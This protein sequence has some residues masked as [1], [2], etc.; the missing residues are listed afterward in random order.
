MAEIIDKFKEKAKGVKDVVVDTA[1][2]L[3]NIDVLTQKF[4]LEL[5]GALA[6]ENAGL[7]RL[8]TRVHEVSMPEAKQR[9]LWHIEESLEHQKILQQLVSGIGAKPTLDKLGLPLPVYPPSMLDMM[10]N[11]MTKQEWELKRSEED[12][13]LEKA[14]VTCYFMLIQKIKMVGGVF[15]TAID[16]LSNIMSDEQNMAEW[17][18]TNSPAMMAQLWPKMQSAIATA[19]SPTSSISPSQSQ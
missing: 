6:M 14:E 3:P 15:L 17:I 11:T 16:P 19:S 5:N 7:E 13:I 12:L 4:A 10:K 8:Q 9:M 18:R 2:S 1:K